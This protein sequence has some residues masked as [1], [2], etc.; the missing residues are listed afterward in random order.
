MEQ[1][2]CKWS[3]LTNRVVGSSVQV[4]LGFPHHKEV[5]GF[6]FNRDRGHFAEPCSLWPWGYLCL[7]ELIHDVGLLWMSPVSF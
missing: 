4:R 3:L 5:L 6:F 7:W 2:D 1:G